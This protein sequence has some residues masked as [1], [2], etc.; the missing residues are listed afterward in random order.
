MA[1]KDNHVRTVITD[2]YSMCLYDH[3][4]WPCPAERI[5]QE[6][7]KAVLEIVQPTGEAPRCCDTCADR[8]ADRSEL[9]DAIKE[10]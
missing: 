10:L 9:A 2:D 7:I 5:K 4:I 8:H 6:V 1:W 3:E